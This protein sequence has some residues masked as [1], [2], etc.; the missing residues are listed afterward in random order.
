M[1]GRHVAEEADEGL[2]R[3]GGARHADAV[4]LGEADETWPKIVA[5]AAR[6]KLKDVYSP[7]DDFGQERKPALKDYPVIPWDTINLDQFNLVP[8]MAHRTLQK[9]GEGW[10]TFRIIPMESG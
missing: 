6:G 9:I 5:D 3:S 10:G 4:A 7:V 1:G 8:K 2:G